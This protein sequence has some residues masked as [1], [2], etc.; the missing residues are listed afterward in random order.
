MSSIDERVVQMKFNN[1]Q[2]SQGVKQTNADLDALKKGLNL[3]ASAK[4]LQGLD[5]AG[6][7]FSLA[8]IANGVDQLASKFTALSIV[9]ITALT[10]IANRAVNA[11]VSM[12]KSLTVDPIKS[13]LAEYELQLNSIQTI[14]ANTQAKGSTLT[15]VNVAL[16]ELNTYADKTIYNFAEMSRNIGTFTAAGVDLETSTSAIKGIANLAALSGS[17]SM[18]AS[19][20]M[21]QLSQAMS[22]G[23][24]K[25]MDWNSVVNAG[26]GGQVFQDALK[27][28]ARNQGV[29]IDGI[30]EKNGS[31]RESLQEGWLTTE[32]MT[33]TLSKLTG[34]LTDDQLKTMGYTEDQIIG[35]QKM[36][37][38]ASDAATKVKTFT[39]LIDTLREAAGSG[40]AQSWQIMLGDFEEAKVLFTDVSNVLGGMIGE[41]SDARNAMLQGWKDLGGRTAAID[42][43]SNAFNAMMAVIRPVIKAFNEIFPPM[44]G[45][46]L[47]DITVAIRDF[48]A[49][50]MP[51]Q[52]SMIAIQRIFRGLFSVLDIGWMIIKGFAGVFVDL[53]GNMAGG[54]EGV[55]LFL[56]KIGDF[57]Y[58]VRNAIKEGEG[59]NAFFEGLGKVLRIPIDMIKKLVGFLGE[60]FSGMDFSG[61]EG[62]GDRLTARFS[63]LQSL[64]ETLRNVWGGVVDVFQGIMEGLAPIVGKIGDFL[65]DFANNAGDAMSNIDFSLILDGINT[66][67]F[68]GLILLIRKFFKG[69]FKEAAE[70]GGEGMIDTIK[71]M[72]NGV[73]DT[74]G[75]MQAQLKAKTLLAIAVALAVLTASIV[76]LSMIDS[77]KLTS[78]LAGMAVMFT[79]LL[80]GMT[81]LDRV[82]TSTGFLKLPFITAALI[83]LAAALVILASAVKM[84]SGLSWNELAKGLT[85]VTVLLGALAVAAN[86]MSRHLGGL[87]SAGIAMIA[88]A[89]AIKILASAVKDFS[90]LSWEELAK[91]LTGVGATLTAL[92][93][94]TRLAKVGKGAMTSSVG[95]I[96][97]AAA[98]KIMASA[99]KDFTGFNWEEMGRGFAGL[100][101]ALVAV[102]VGMRLMPTNMVMQAAAIAILGGSL[103]IMASAMKDFSKMKWDEIG[104]GLTAMGAAL[105]I[106]A[107]GMRAMPKSMLLSAASL[108]VV[109]GALKIVASV[110]EDMGG[111][112]WGEIAKSMVVL[113][114]SL[115][116]IAA[117]LYLMTAAIPGAL[118][119]IVAAGALAILAPV[120]VALGDMTWGE[121]A[122]GLTMLAAALVII[123]AGGVLLLVA[124]P[125]LLGLGIAALAIGAGALMAG[126]GLTAMALALTALSIALPLVTVGI[127]GLV[128]GILTLIPTALEQ[129]ALGIVIF[130]QTLADNGPV[131]LNAMIT[132]ILTLLQG[133]NTI[134]PQIALTMLNLILTLLGLLASHVPQFVDSGMRLLIGILDGIANN[135]HQLVT[136]ATDV[137]VAFIDGISDNLP[138][139]IDSG[140]NLVVS[141]VQGV[142]DGI[143]NNQPA[144]TAAGQDLAWAIADGMTGGLASK[145]KGLAESAAN[146]ARNALQAAKDA[147]GI[148]SPSKEFFKVGEWSVEG[149][150]LAIDKNAHKVADSSKNMGNQALS[151]IQKSLLGVAEFIDSD[152]ELSPTITPIL[153]LSKVEADAEGL[154]RLIPAQNL[155]L[156]K[157]FDRAKWLTDQQNNRLNSP[158]NPAMSLED[159]SAG[160]KVEYIQNNYSPKALS[161][162]EIYRQT[163]NQ[164]S[165]VKGLVGA[166]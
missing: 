1:A 87:I 94:F 79:Q 129:L 81:I 156:M 110:L 91:G 3:D 122:A 135:I 96:L 29:A 54:T 21:Y 9:G 71:G 64:G 37:A 74:L 50:L 163:H 145:A 159:K 115:V 150:T 70:E 101:G 11:G 5:A 102:A 51:S 107:I 126:I 149:M 19:T 14:L 25:L 30:I 165:T 161:T 134:A 93:L 18:Q 34:D 2:F 142:A 75:A 154:N 98:L 61:L 65:G 46:R 106:V 97:L 128:T 131:F 105:L 44:T 166:K 119:L 104:R 143:S 39:Q 92:T 77:K 32:V 89:A 69:G 88:V 100:A 152:I 103:K 137:V 109:A 78:A 7:K 80:V 6:K 153:D 151:A 63:P 4:S 99:V 125:G 43:I 111:M 164:I 33:E 62:V 40:W 41:A 113:A 124:L 160:M 140:M 73:T 114:G 28:T 157:T 67:L 136:S 155:S 48:T 76:A 158:S 86:V 139:I 84:M 22:S 36:A 17:N 83:P 141:F 90:S 42:A 8:G 116:I 47:F 117:A 23:T 144:M 59:L 95:L 60:M 55:L 121:I 52:A 82:S 38:T 130:V 120:L 31:F 24:V 68:A 147:L 58:G 49:S 10:N 132:L 118:A 123:A 12:A 20:A 108:V 45:Q 72:F 53:I 27:E 146:M 138:R 35:I 112:S 85:G 162:I 16:A 66:G 148:E 127:V 57:L 13:G 133:I 56:A 26:M 15:D